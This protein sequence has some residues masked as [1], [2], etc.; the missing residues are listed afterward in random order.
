V[1]LSGNFQAT[2]WWRLR[3]GYTYLDKNIWAT[4][5]AVLR[6]SD[7]FEANDPTHQV[8]FQSIMDLPWHF[9]FD[10]VARYVTELQSPAIQAYFTMDI[11]VAWQFKNLEISLVGQNLCDNQ[12]PEFTSQEIP[13]S[14]YGKVTW[15]F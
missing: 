13:R 15:R 10:A 7:T 2:D 5:P 9:Q 3:G 8:L 11:R 14:V 12:H 6:G 4:S 1:E